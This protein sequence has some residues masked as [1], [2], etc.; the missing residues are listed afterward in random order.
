MA[1]QP[2]AGEFQDSA[3]GFPLL[4]KKQIVQVAA[5]DQVPLVLSWGGVTFWRSGILSSHPLSVLPPLTGYN[6]RIRAKC[7]TN[8][9]KDAMRPGAVPV[10][11]GVCGTEASLGSVLQ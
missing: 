6:E 1:P 5:A 7:Q 10:T 4:E 2:L 3:S 11:E 9:L 8:S